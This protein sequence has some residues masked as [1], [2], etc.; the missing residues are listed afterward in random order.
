MLQRIS[1]LWMISTTLGD[2]MPT[3]RLLFMLI[4]HELLMKFLWNLEI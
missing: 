4:I 1:I 3:T 2:R